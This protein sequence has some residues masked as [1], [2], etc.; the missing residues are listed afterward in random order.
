MKKMIL[1]LALILFSGSLVFATSKN[2]VVLYNGQ[3]ETNRHAAQ[4]IMRGFRQMAPDYKI[5]FTNRPNDITA[6][7]Q[8]A[9]IILNTGLVSG[10]DP[11][12]TDFIKTYRNKNELLVISLEKYNRDTQVQL[13]S[14]K[15]NAIGIDAVTGPSAWGN[16]ALVNAHLAWLDEIFKF[17]K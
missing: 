11:A 2:I 9:V 17:I 8:K 15:N 4:F 7:Q 16:Q 1:V 10:I 3:S 13:S 5:L 14:A 6:G 12:F